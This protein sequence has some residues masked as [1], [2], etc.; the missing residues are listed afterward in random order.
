MHPVTLTEHFCYA[1]DCLKLYE[2]EP[3]LCIRAPHARG[4]WKMDPVEKP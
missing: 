4:A 3:A 1:R 2:R